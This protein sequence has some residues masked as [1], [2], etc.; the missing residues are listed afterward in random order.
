MHRVHVIR[1]RSRSRIERC[2][3]RPEQIWRSHVKVVVQNGPTCVGGEFCPLAQFRGVDSLV[4]AEGVHD[5]LAKT[6][7]VNK[8]LDA[9]PFAD[10][11]GELVEALDLNCRSGGFATVVDSARICRGSEVI[12]IPGELVIAVDV[13]AVAGGVGAL[14]WRLAGLAPKT[15]RFL[16]VYKACAIRQLRISLSR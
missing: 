12:G 7:P 3:I 10:L 16:C 9:L 13:D 14:G 5:V 11:A 2:P 1:R 8:E 6:V 15:I 4:V